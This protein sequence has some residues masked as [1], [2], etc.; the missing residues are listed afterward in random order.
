[1]LLIVRAINFHVGLQDFTFIFICPLDI[2]SAIQSAVTSSEDSLQLA[3]CS[4]YDNNSKLTTK[5][6]MLIYWHSNVADKGGTY[7]K[8]L[9]ETAHGMVIIRSGTPAPISACRSN[10]FN[11]E[12]DPPVLCE[13]DHKPLSPSQKPVKFFTHL[14]ELYSSPGE[15]ILDGLSGIGKLRFRG[16]EFSDTKIEKALK[17]QTHKKVETVIDKLRSRRS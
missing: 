6:L 5:T 13:I 7:S 1:L 3:V 4:F 12:K 2:L 8:S 14:I 10:S 17:I 11:F 16:S 15:W 9:I